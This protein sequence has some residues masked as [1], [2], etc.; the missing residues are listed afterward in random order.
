MPLSPLFARTALG[1]PAESRHYRRGASLARKGGK[2]RILNTR[3][4]VL[5]SPSARREGI[6][7][8]VKDSHLKQPIEVSRRSRGPRVVFS[9]KPRN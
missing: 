2:N 6:R 1:R 4:A 3:M 7:G 5:V 9:N 8:R